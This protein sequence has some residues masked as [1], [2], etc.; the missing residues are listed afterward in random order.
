MRSSEEETPGKQPLAFPRVFV[1]KKHAEPIR[2][3]PV[4]EHHSRFQTFKL[5]N[6]LRPLKMTFTPYFKRIDLVNRQSRLADREFE[7]AYEHAQNYTNK[8]KKELLDSSLQRE[9]NKIKVDTISHC[10]RL[11]KKKNEELE[12]GSHEYANYIVSMVYS[13]SNPERG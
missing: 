7:E 2:F 10:K 12:R 4:M 13:A 3:S 11:A 9:I 8:L 6:I 5:K 1:S